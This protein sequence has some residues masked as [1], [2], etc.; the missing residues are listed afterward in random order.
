M[1][2]SAGHG[3]IY[4][5]RESTVAAKA[6]NDDSSNGDMTGKVEEEAEVKV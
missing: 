6:T 2:V 4:R 3:M 5:S 1:K